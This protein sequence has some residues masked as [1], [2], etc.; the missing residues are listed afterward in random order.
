MN[1]ID[2]K[3]QDLKSN[4]QKAFIAYITAGDP[5]L[6]LTEELVLALE[7]SGVD[8]I[9]L[10]VPF[11]DPMADGTTIQAASQRALNQGT[12]LPKIFEM[13]KR[14]RQ[15]SQLPIALMTYYNPVFSYG[16]E[17]FINTCKSIGVDGVIIPDLP[18]EEASV[19]R[20]AAKKTNISTIFFIA[21]TTTDERMKA[22]ARAATGFIYYVALAG[23]TGTKQAVAKDVVNQIKKLKRYTDKPICAGFGISN[24][25][26]ARS[27]AQ[28]ADGVIVGSAI[29]KEIEKHAG[30]ADCVAQVSRYVASLV[31]AVH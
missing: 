19:L 29:I 13:V 11:S 30:K 26:Q 5:N 9:E 7:K 28:M 10:G 2:Q 20:H 31:K 3:F 12:T 22:N 16:D 17:N 1:R 4:K 8:M 27:I 21:P 15:K 14:L 24:A 18:P 6:Q 23:V 25:E